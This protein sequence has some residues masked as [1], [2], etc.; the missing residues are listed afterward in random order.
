MLPSAVREVLPLPPERYRNGATMYGVRVVATS[1]A[2]KDLYTDDA[3]ALEAWTRD[4][5]RST[6]A[7]R[8]AAY[9]KAL[10]AAPPAGALPL[11]PSRRP[12]GAALLN[13]LHLGDI[14]EVDWSGMLGSGLFACVLRGRLHEGG[15]AV[16][17]KI[18][19]K[20]AMIEY[21]E[22]VYR[23]AQV[24]SAVGVHPHI[25]QLKQVRRRRLRW[26]AMLWRWQGAR[27]QRESGTGCAAGRTCLLSR[28]A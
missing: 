22:I 20:E 8:Q 14:C 11:P 27:V 23:E 19:K 25:C 3:A 5:A 24:W 13:E 9:R 6:P 2:T 4:L 28:F 15:E 7:A 18:I 21:S 1:G 16:A 17:V 12:G 10:M 26:R